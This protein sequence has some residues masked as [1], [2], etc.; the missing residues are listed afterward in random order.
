MSRWDAAPTPQARSTAFLQS[1][2]HHQ[3]SPAQLLFT[4]WLTAQTP[5]LMKRGE[6]KT[7]GLL[8]SS[9]VESSSKPIQSRL[10]ASLSS[11]AFPAPI[12]LGSRVTLME[13]WEG[14][15]WERQSSPEPSC[16]CS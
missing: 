14:T 10:I 9:L 2:P 7:T 6:M 11:K 16:L 13:D 12:N 5:S 15:S 4:L 1:H 8:P 3:A